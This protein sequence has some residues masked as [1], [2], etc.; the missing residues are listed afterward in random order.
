MGRSFDQFHRAW[1]RLASALL[2]AEAT[3]ASAALASLWSGRP[4]A[5]EALLVIMI[6][7]SLLALLDH[8][9]GRRR[10]RHRD[11]REKELV[12]GDQEEDG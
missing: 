9:L 1:S 7:L 5:A 12:R 2:L 3:L 10:A 11:Q 6:G 4:N 8:R